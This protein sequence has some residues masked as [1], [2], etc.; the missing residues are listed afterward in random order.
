MT[1]D[2]RRDMLGIFWA[3]IDAP[4]EAQADSNCRMGWTW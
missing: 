4:D 1:D 3:A 2:A